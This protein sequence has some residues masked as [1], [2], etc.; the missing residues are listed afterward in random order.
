MTEPLA[1]A[2]KEAIENL[3]FELLHAERRLEEALAETDWLTDEI[4]RMEKVIAGT[5]GDDYEITAINVTPEMNAIAQQARGKA[6]D[7]LR[8]L[9]ATYERLAYQNAVYAPV[10]ESAA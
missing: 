4:N 3:R 7:E 2:S 5:G 1:P 9:N 8:T 10:K 6:W